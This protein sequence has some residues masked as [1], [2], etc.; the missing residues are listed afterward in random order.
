MLTIAAALHDD[1]SR[2]RLVEVDQCHNRAGVGQLRDQRRYV[3]R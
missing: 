2:L 3:F 1:G